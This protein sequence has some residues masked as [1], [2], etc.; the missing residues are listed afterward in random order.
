M[1]ASSSGAQVWPHHVILGPGKCAMYSNNPQF[2][3]ALM[4]F[5][6]GY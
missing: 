1:N 5:L 4:L 6:I 2:Y 3:D